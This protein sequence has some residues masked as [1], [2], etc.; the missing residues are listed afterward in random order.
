MI[1]RAL[2]LAGGI[3]GAAALSQYPE[4]SQQ[5][6]QRLG[7]QVDALTL[8]VDE[9]DRSASANGLTRR[10]ALDQMQGTPFLT[11]RK[12]DMER[13]FDR[14][15]RLSQNLTFLRL[16]T[17]LER[18]TMPHRMADRDTIRATWADFRPALPLTVAGAVAAALGF[19]GGWGAVRLLLWPLRKKR[20]AA[21]T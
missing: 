21:L 5:Y 10:A 9:F 3:S 6:I 4:F 7:G 19:L 17:P 14:Q 20:R 2:A 11:A 16:A 1:V 18:I 8:M 15:A 12:A 13:A